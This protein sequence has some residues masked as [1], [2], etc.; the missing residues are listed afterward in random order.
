MNLYAMRRANGDW[1]A[2]DDRGSL[3]VP[4]FRSSRDAQV[5]RSRDSGMECFRA[6]ALDEGAF[7][8]L[9]TTSE[10][11]AK[12]WLVENPLIKLSRGRELDSAQL[13][14]LML[15]GNTIAAKTR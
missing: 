2:L 12:F 9:T 14:L 13:A 10:G 6:V 11:S 1:Y 3:R 8:N 5:A 15:N 4:V 7:L